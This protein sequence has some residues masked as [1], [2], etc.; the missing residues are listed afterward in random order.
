MRYYIIFLV[1]LFTGCTGIPDGI[2]PVKN[3]DV[4][5]YLGKWYEIARLDHTFE[6][7]LQHITAEYSMRE[8]GGI[9]V[10]NRGFKVA[11]NRWNEAQGKAY[12]MGDSNT[13]HLKVSFFGPFYGAYI[14]FDLGKDYEYALVTS[15]DRS[16]FWLLSRTPIINQQLKE[17]LLKRISVLGFQ[18]QDLIFV[19]QLAEIKK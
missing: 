11:S 9:K 6:R 14:V 19:E 4:N 2:K 10:L 18:T 15:S 7:G 1:L 16:Y 5:R 3:F 13:G 12:F 8:D 17:S